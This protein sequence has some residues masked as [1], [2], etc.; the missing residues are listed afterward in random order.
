MIKLK[1]TFNRA[2]C[3]AGVDNTGKSYAFVKVQAVT[4]EG[5]TVSIN[6]DPTEW[7]AISQQFRMFDI[8]N[9]PCESIEVDKSGRCDK[10]GIPFKHAVNPSW[11]EAE[12]VKQGFGVMPSFELLKKNADLTS[13]AAQATVT[14]ASDDM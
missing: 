5:V 2:K 3:F 11:G 8:I 9:V 12:V 6:I 13:Q 4:P 7:F 10:N 14:A 1:T